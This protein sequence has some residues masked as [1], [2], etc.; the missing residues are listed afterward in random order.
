MDPLVFVVDDEPVIA[1]TLA[2]ILQ[3][4]NFEARAFVDPVEALSAARQQS[5]T[6]LLSDVVM[7]GMTGIELAIAICRESPD[8]RVLLFSGQARS[9]E[10]LRVAAASGHNFEL[11][12]KPVHPKDLLA[13]LA[14][15]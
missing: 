12:L 9:A 5:P 3:K 7:P 1:H 4:A 15:L 8:C 11:L 6:L 14:S 13:R 10:L 2:A